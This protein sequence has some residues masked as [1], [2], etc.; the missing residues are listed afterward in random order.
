MKIRFTWGSLIAVATVATGAIAQYGPTVAAISPKAGG[1]I[2][3]I[4]A[5][6][7]L[8]TKSVASFNSDSIPAAN[9]VVAGPIVLEKTGPLKSAS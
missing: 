4:G 9:K 2:M 5:I 8:V 7:G 6:L 1:I 3:T